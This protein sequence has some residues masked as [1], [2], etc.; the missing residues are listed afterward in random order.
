MEAAVATISEERLDG[1]FHALAD[2]TRRAILARLARRPATVSDLAAPFEISLPAVSKHL[3]VLERAGW[4]SR[5]I[6]GRQHLCSL[7]AGALQD[8][9]EW[10]GPYRE[11]WTA[12]FAA[13]AEALSPVESTPE[14]RHRERTTRRP[15]VPRRGGAAGRHRTGRLV[16]A[17]K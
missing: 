4:I 11:F 9:E 14:I 6:D 10:L 1:V 2:P 8:V 3:K 16:G 12:H 15:S 13:L 5:D 7:D 17:D